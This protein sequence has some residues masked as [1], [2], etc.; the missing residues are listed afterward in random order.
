[1]GNTLHLDPEIV[2]ELEQRMHAVA[3]K[4]Q[5][6]S[7]LITSRAQ[8]MAWTGPARDEFMQY[9]YDYE[10]EQARA[11]EAIENLR[12]RLIR[13]LNE[14]LETD[15]AFASS[16]QQGTVKGVSTRRPPNAPKNTQGLYKMFVEMG[17]KKEMLK[18]V[19]VNKN[20]FVIL[21]GGTD[22]W[23]PKSVVSA[24]DSVYADESGLEKFLKENL[25]KKIPKGATLHFAGYSQ[26]G[27]VALDLVNDK[28]FAN[29][30]FKRGQVVTFGA[31][32]D[33]LQQTRQDDLIYIDR[34]DFLYTSAAPVYFD[35]K[36]FKYV[37]LPDEVLHHGKYEEIEY[38]E[39]PTFLKNNTEWTEVLSEDWNKLED[40]SLLEKASAY[41][42]FRESITRPTGEYIAGKTKEVLWK[43]VEITLSFGKFV[44]HEIKDVSTT[45]VDR[46]Q[47]ILEY[48]FAEASEEISAEMKEIY[49]TVTEEASEVLDDLESVANTIKNKLPQVKWVDLPQCKS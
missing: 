6:A 29:S 13:E 47:E 4:V 33:A 7:R 14:W 23:N 27:Y 2:R 3:Q 1:M 39:V 8:S 15:N 45:V 17:K 40:T 42:E 37:N 19:R 38:N 46:G 18:V 35:D 22:P 49:T 48:T 11:Y 41:F 32:P 12:Q 21:L 36:Q 16:A 9:M 5:E 24:R 10:R 20:E 34:K 30:G 26:G 25:P 28:W 31:I 44:V 43:P